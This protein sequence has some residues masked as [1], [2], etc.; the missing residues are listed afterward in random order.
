MSQFIPVIGAVMLVFCAIWGF[1]W[2]EVLHDP[3]NE[4]K[5]FYIKHP[6]AKAAVILANRLW[7]PMLVFGVCFSIAGLVVG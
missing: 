5:E 2:L 1:L 4:L 7:V 3:K 6:Q